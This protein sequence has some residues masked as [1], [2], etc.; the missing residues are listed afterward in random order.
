M[1]SSPIIRNSPLTINTTT[2]ESTLNSTSSPKPYVSYDSPRMTS[3]SPILKYS[4]ND[5]DSNSKINSETYKVTQHSYKSTVRQGASPSPITDGV[6]YSSNIK[7]FNTS[8]GRRDSWDVINKTKHMF[9]NNSLESL[10]KLTEEQLDTDLLTRTKELDSQTHL[11]TQFNKFALNNNSSY[12]S[13]IDT[14]QTNSYHTTIR[15]HN[16][17]YS[18]NSSKDH[19]LE[20]S[21]KFL[22]IEHDIVGGA[23]AIKVTNKPDGI[24]GR[25]FEFESE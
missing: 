13:G 5:Y 9:S 3:E 10:A 19:E 7:S 15:E 14:Q 25:P 20:Y 17:V 21:S 6:D 24:L 23:K 12:K 22:P 16:E 1:R 8:G 18:T 11:N 2:Y 4:T